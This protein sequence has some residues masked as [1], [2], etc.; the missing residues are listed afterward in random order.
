MGWAKNN[1]KSLGI[2]QYIKTAVLVSIEQKAP[3]ATRG[4]GICDKTNYSCDME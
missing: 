3:M 4:V 2:S 1:L